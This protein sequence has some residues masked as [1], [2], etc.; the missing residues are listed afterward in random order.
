MRGIRDF[1]E[2]LR[3]MDPTVRQ[4]DFVFVSMQRATRGL[5]GL[6]P[7]LIFHEEEGV[8]LILEKG[9]ADRAGLE[10]EGVWACITLN[11]HSDLEA[12]G[13]IAAVATALAREQIPCNTVS[14]F[15]HDHIFVPKAQSERSLRILRGLT[16]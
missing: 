8:S 7:L 14:A 1:S 3:R 6:Q 9:L 5:A 16:K 11:V 12:V 10:Y 13:L 15:Y 2:L 4:G